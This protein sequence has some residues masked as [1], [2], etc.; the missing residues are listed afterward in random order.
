MQCETLK[1]NRDKELEIGMF[2]KKKLI[3]ENQM[4]G[5]LI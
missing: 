4:K 1:R 5:R 3:G 2:L